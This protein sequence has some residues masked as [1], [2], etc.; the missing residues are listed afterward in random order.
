MALE[1][2]V[3]ERL[4]P[5]LPEPARAAIEQAR[6]AATTVRT[7]VRERLNQAAAL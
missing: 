7:Q 2:I 1:A 5:A 3:F 6:A 4:E